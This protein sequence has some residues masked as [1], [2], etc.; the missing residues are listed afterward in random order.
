MTPTDSLPKGEAF[1]LKALESSPGGVLGVLLLIIV[2]GTFTFGSAI[3]I[4]VWRTLV[5]WTKGVVEKLVTKHVEFVDST[6]AGLDKSSKANVRAASA[7]AAVRKGQKSAA[8][9]HK[10]HAEHLQETRDRLEET[11]METKELVGMLCA[12]LSK[13]AKKLGVDIGE[14]LGHIQAVLEEKARR[15]KEP[16]VCPPG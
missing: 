15:G 1:W 5:P 12:M 16:P 2:I 4:I 3:L 10:E 14:E 8:T 6:K 9:R 13:V 11:H 7:M